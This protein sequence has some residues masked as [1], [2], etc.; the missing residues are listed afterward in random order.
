MA[1]LSLVSKTDT[2]VVL[3]VT[4][5]PS[6]VSSV[7]FK[8]GGFDI[9]GFQ[10][11]GQTVTGSVSNGVATA[12]MSGF[13]TAGN[14]TFS[15]S[16]AYTSTIQ[17]HH[18]VYAGG[19]MSFVTE[20]VNENLTAATNTITVYLNG[21]PATPTTT[22]TTTVNYTTPVLSFVS[23][24]DTSITLKATN[25]PSSISTVTFRANNGISTSASVSSGSATATL[26]GFTTS[27]NYS[28][29]A[30]YSYQGTTEETQP[31]YTGGSHPSGYHQVAVTTT[32]T[33]TSN[34]ITV[35]LNGSPTAYTPPTVN[36]TG[37]LALASQT[38]TSVTVTLSNIPSYVNSPITFTASNGVTAT[39]Y[40]YGTSSASATLSPFNSAGTY[41]IWASYSMPRD[42]SVDGRHMVAGESTY[43][44]NSISV[45]MTGDVI[46]KVIQ[47]LTNPQITVS[48]QV[49]NTAGVGIP[50][51]TVVLSPMSGSGNS[52]TTTT[53]QYGN[54]SFTTTLTSVN[55]TV[56]AS[57]YKKYSIGE[58]V[59]LTLSGQ[60][61]TTHI[62]HNIVLQP[63]SE[64]VYIQPVNPEPYPYYPPV[65]EQPIGA[66]S[67]TVLGKVTD[68]STGLPIAGVSVSTSNNQHTTTA[69]DGT[70]AILESYTSSKPSTVSFSAN[71][72]N[73]TAVS[74]A[75]IPNTGAG[76][77]VNYVVNASL[78]PV[79]QTQTQTQ[80]QNNSNQQ[81][82]SQTQTQNNS[83]NASTT[84]SQTSTNYGMSS[85][86]ASGGGTSSNLYSTTSTQPSPS[87]TSSDK[88][89][90]IIGGIAVTGLLALLAFRKKR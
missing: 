42:I 36:G 12:T 37:T 4:G 79:T 60:P 66:G 88:T 34:T 31:V 90:W 62:T 54:Y 47:D 10:I 67:I 46:S 44:S 17:E 74:T 8:Q 73:A 58:G 13:T 1:T 15:A 64:P 30:S 85:T 77:F 32:L 63:L 86:G 5:I 18:P 24:T 9:L 20:P 83:N 26:S 80:N 33:K 21:T 84:T 16:Y 27:G 22:T 55:L 14:Y 76:E 69:S 51:A 40:S 68:S 50:N 71:G 2:S 72:Y 7:Q 52:Q 89:M 25:I 48:G 61:T 29:T 3:Q 78:T 49:T 35:Y 82:T 81:N 56:N 45:T 19:H 28:F 57:G 75:G 6:G 53:D 59:T 65:P 39:G 23:N 43:N 70:Y 41:K 11:G 87:P 38:D